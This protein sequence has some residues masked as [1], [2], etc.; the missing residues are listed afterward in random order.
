MRLETPQQLFPQKGI[1]TLDSLETAKI[2]AYSKTGC[3]KIELRFGLTKL[4]SS[5][6]HTTFDVTHFDW[7]TN[8]TNVLLYTPAKR[9]CSYNNFVDWLNPLL[10]RGA[11]TPLWTML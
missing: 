6:E 10:V 11:V 5:F 2:F 9:Q 3:L 4:I 1:S 7:G 8:D